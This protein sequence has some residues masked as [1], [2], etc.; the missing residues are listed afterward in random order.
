MRK[1]LHQ[2]PGL[3]GRYSATRDGDIFSHLS[4]QFLKPYLDSRGYHTCSIS[5]DKYWTKVSYHSLIART[6][7]GNCPDGFEIDHINRNRSDNRVE[8]LR[9]V[10]RSTNT[11]NREAAG[12][13]K[14][15]GVIFRKHRA[16]TKPWTA[17]F[18][19]QGKRFYLPYYKT[20][21]EAAEAVST[22]RMGMATTNKSLGHL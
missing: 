2:I 11:Q 4:D 10:S 7:L 21:E 16:T 14:L 22:A 13:W 20:K 1:E 5:G 15:K 6:F 9:Y 12:Q 3:E 19:F 17:S 8:N 18:R